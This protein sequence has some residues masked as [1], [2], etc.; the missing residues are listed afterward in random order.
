MQ[1]IFLTS[2]ELAA[3]LSA[4]YPR[5]YNKRTLD[6]WRHLGCGPKFCKQAGRVLYALERVQEWEANGGAL[7][8]GGRK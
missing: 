4:R 5:P 3:Y 8:V 6:N 1:P 2:L 7:R